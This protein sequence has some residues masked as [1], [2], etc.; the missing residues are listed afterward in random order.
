VASQIPKLKQ[1][2]YDFNFKLMVIKHAEY[3]SNCT[4][5][6]KFGVAELTV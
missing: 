3:A 6:W 1:W 2:S 5:A 4:A